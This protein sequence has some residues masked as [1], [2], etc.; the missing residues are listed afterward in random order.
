MEQKNNNNEIDWGGWIVALIALGV[1]WPV[2]LVLLFRMLMG[3]GRSSRRSPSSVKR[4]PYDLQQEAERAAAAG[5]QTSSARTASSPKKQ[6]AAQSAGA[7]AAQRA[8]EQNRNGKG[9][10]GRSPVDL[11]KG[12]A[13]M[14]VGAGVAGVFGIAFLSTVSDILSY[15]WSGYY[16]GDLFTLGGFLSGGLVCLYAGLRRRKQAR[17]FKKYLAYIGRNQ[18]I[19]LSAL[20]AAM[21]VKEKTICEDLQD[22]LDTGVLP[23]GYIDLAAGRLVLSDEG[24]SDF[25]AE[26][27]PEP[28]PVKKTV[29]DENAILQEIRMVNDAIPDAVMSA[30]IDR[31]GEI[32]GKI[33]DY[34]RSHPGKSGQ[35]R[36]FL[37]YYLPTTL[38]VLRAYAQLDAQGIEGENISAA[39]KRIEGMMDQVVDGFEK[40]LDKLFQDDALDITSD[41]EVLENMLKKDGL[42]GGMTMDGGFSSGSGDFSPQQAYLDL[43]KVADELE[44]KNE[45]GG[46]GITL[47]L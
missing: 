25:A 44:E 41:V 33:L 12:K 20:A 19:S 16:L 30:K 26:P 45:E 42:A 43:R 9:R 11:S 7:K 5:N 21:G 4:H 34:Q 31:I 38:K 18:T 27:E 36:S 3:Y 37:N 32:T 28:E 46:Q 10:T 1:F 8:A 24:I 22:M 47:G 39:K 2:G 40:Q 23:M 17:R 35:L 6:A 29:E 14:I 13:L 15:G